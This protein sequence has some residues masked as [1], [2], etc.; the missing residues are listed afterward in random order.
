MSSRIFYH[1]PPDLEGKK[2]PTRLDSYGDTGKRYYLDPWTNLPYP[3]VTTV[4]SATNP[5]KD[6]GLEE[7]RNRVGPGVADHIMHNAKSVGSLAH[8]YCEGHLNNKEF[9]P[10]QPLLAFAHYTNLI[11]ELEQLDNIK[12]TEMPLLSAKVGAAGTVDC[13]AE[14]CQVPSIVDFK[15][16]RKL[17]KDEWMHDYYVQVAAYGMM[18]HDMFNERIE[19]GVIMCSAEDGERK[20]VVVRLAEY[21]HEWLS[22][23]AQ[24]KASVGL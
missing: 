1:R 24:Y 20:V 15:T 2:P 5:D 21:E 3:S 23:V 10:P 16:M 11:P 12:A 18:W 9:L 6:S 7:W 17:K 4:L 19:Q 8:A 14:Y 13:V 22:R